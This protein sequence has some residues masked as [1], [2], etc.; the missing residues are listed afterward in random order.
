MKCKVHLLH[1][2]VITYRTVSVFVCV[3]GSYWGYGCCITSN[4]KSLVIWCNI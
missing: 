3:S 4:M 1:I 2:S